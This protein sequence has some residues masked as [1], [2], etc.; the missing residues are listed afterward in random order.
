MRV[1]NTLKK[2]MKNKKTIGI[3]SVIGALVLAIILVSVTITQSLGKVDVITTNKNI[4]KGQEITTSDLTVIKMN[5]GDVQENYILK[6]EEAD[7]KFATVDIV[8]GDILTNSKI[9]KDATVGDNQFLSIPS[10]KQA[11]SFSVQ[12]G[13]DSLSNKLI[14]GDIIRVY[15]YEQNGNKSSK[16]YS[17]EELQFLQIANITSSAYKDVDEKTKESEDEKTS[18]YAT[19][20][21]IVDSV[22]AEKLI[23]LQKEGGVYVT[24]ISR[25]ND[26]V[27]EQVL[28]QQESF[29]RGD[30]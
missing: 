13:A 16:V 5:K 1:D 25:G 4:A 29:L 12:G 2:T 18:T 17:P 14:A 10:G 19:I 24:L 9:A 22:Q 8:S 26:K 7:K 23:Q 28:A 6:T 30:K 3:I 27:T 15:T 11:I 20:T 21:V